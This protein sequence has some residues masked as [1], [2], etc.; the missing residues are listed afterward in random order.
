MSWLPTLDQVKLDTLSTTLADFVP[1]MEAQLAS[2]DI[3]GAS[4]SVLSL[5]RFYTV[6][7]QTP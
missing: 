4:L 2:K 7:R 5:A 1:L 3:S 6:N